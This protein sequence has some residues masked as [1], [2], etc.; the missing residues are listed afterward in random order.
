[1]RGVVLGQAPLRTGV[2]TGFDY[3][4]DIADTLALIDEVIDGLVED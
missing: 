4:V 1:V 2:A 3:R